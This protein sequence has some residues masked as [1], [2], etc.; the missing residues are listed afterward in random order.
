MY[1]CNNC[2]RQFEQ[3]DTIKEKSGEKWYVCPYCRGADF[4]EIRSR[5][6]DFF[7]VEK[8]VVID[9]AVS[10]L[11]ALNEQDTD[12][13]KE[14]LTELVSELLGESPFEYKDSL[15]TIVENRKDKLILTLC[16]ALEVVRV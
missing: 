14:I 9:G 15:N 7:Y 11:A 13:A 4:D 16:E 12:G 3:Y 10:A 5:N 1:K 6:D 2:N 8:A